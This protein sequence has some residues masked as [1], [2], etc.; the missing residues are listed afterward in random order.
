MRAEEETR[1]PLSGISVIGLGLLKN[2]VRQRH[3]LPFLI[4]KAPD[5]IARTYLLA[6]ARADCPGPKMTPGS[7]FVSIL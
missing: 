4:I 7:S 2:I 3:A 5:D 6:K 1:I